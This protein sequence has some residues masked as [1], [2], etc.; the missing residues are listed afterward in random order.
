MKKKKSFFYNAFSGYFTQLLIWLLILFILRP[1]QR[2]TVYMTIW[3]LAFIVVFFSALFNCKH[4]K[5]VKIIATGLA[6]PAFVFH[7]LSFFY[8][9]RFLVA[10][11]ITFTLLFVSFIA[12]A[13]LYTVILHATVTLETLR[14]VICAYFMIG[15]AFAFAYYLVEFFIPGSIHFPGAPV[16]HDNFHHY[17][18]E[19]MYFSFV[20]LIGIGYGDIV[21]THDAAQTLSVIEGTIGQFFIAILVARLVAVYSLRGVTKILREANPY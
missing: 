10:C 11:S 8:P 6:I 15:F 9:P 7:A 5:R 17:I 14:G 16:Y 1:F 20:T 12:L 19:V 4:S 13:I 18:S 3:Y 21:A 2:G